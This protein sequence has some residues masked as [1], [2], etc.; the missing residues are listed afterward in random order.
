M[1]GLSKIVNNSMKAEEVLI[2][3]LEGRR[4]LESVS[5]TMNEGNS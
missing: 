3:N 4:R 1:K 5:E 2:F